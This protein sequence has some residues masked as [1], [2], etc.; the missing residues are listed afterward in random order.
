MGGWPCRC[1]RWRK[2]KVTIM[3][4]IDMEHFS[5]ELQQRWL[6]AQRLQLEVY[7]QM[8]GA[9]RK[10]LEAQR[11]NFEMT[12]RLMNAQMSLLDTWVK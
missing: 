3:A 8:M 1:H 6:D 10:L 9:S 2:E 5:A 7:E 11:A 12:Q 4:T